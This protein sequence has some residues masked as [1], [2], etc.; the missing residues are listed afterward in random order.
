MFISKTVAAALEIVEKFIPNTAEKERLKTEVIKAQLNGTLE[1]RKGWQ[2]IIENA[3][4][5]KDWLGRSWFAI[6]ALSLCSI[7]LYDFLICSLLQLFG[8]NAIPI[9]IPH[10][11]W[12]LYGIVFGGG[13]G[14]RTTQTVF[15]NRSKR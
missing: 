3:S 10:D 7:L 5:S 15:E 14:M 2:R 13:L 11:L 8:V 4:K 1:I 12:N 9:N 6:I